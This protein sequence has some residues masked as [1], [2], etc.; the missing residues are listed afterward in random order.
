MLVRG[1]RGEGVIKVDS[2]EGGDQS[3]HRRMKE[4]IKFVGWSL[5]GSSAE[6]VNGDDGGERGGRCYDRVRRVTG[7]R[8]PG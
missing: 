8:L 7:H 3:D 2:L 1:E 6:K 4:E 5:G